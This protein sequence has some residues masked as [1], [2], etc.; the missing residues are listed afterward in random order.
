MPEHPRKKEDE[1]KL[2]FNDQAEEREDGNMVVDESSEDES[3][4]DED[5]AYDDD[6]G[7]Y[8]T[9]EAQV[10]KRQDHLTGAFPVT[11]TEL[12]Q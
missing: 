4:S 3:S 5:D 12:Q 6:E 11:D 9:P 7:G 1:Q 2:E 10:V 8:H